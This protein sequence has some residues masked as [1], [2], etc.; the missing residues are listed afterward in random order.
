MPSSKSSS[1][2]PGKKQNG[3][4]VQLQK[5]TKQ[6]LS[7][8]LVGNSDDDSDGAERSTAPKLSIATKKP[9]LVSTK[10]VSTKAPISTA[11][12][13]KKE[14]APG[15]ESGEDAPS[16]SGSES[17]G[18]S[19]D[20]DGGTS[21][22]IPSSQEDNPL[23]VRPQQ[24][25][26]QLS[27]PTVSRETPK[28]GKVSVKHMN[29]IKTRKYGKDE[30]DSEEDSKSVS[31][32]SGSGSESESG[33][34]DQ[35]SLQSP[36][37]KSPTRRPAREQTTQ[38]YKPPPGFEPAS[39]SVHPSS[40]LSEIFAPSNLTGKQ[41]WHITAPASVP[42]ASIK[43]IRGKSIENGTSVLTHNGANYGLLPDA[44][45]EQAGDYALLLPTAQS[46]D[47]SSSKRS[48]NQTLHLQKFVSL[49]SHA[50]PPTVPRP[51]ATAAPVSYK[52][53]SRPQPQGL[54]MRYHPFGASDESESES[55]LTESVPAAPQFQ[56]PNSVNESS[57]QRKRKR[58]ESSTVE[59]GIDATPARPKKRGRKAPQESAQL[60]PATDLPVTISA[61]PADI[62]KE[63]ATIMPEEV[64]EGNPGT[65]E[66][67]SKKKR[68]ADRQKQREME[69]ESATI[70]QKAS[71]HVETKEE[72][73]KR[74]QE[75]KKRRQA[76]HDT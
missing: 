32:S 62:T 11:I 16:G 41:I 10:T 70:T 71:G 22:R 24:K 12:V 40:K 76:A 3:K 56:V 6:A 1:A 31:D 26:A 69:E 57:P 23:P 7:T 42:L 4:T 19:Q 72:R 35:T 58:S 39:I 75:K 65:K 67:S 68:K 18:K 47:Y 50:A 29:H 66:S 30:G 8:E 21:G 60:E 34:S 27:R 9:N 28:S 54:K 45:G 51:D 37:K 73:A 74:K 17:E 13:S 48:I 2:L 14:R 44:D 20:T 53:K 64:V 49:P 59:Q 63:A 25:A 38:P 61:L 36:R 15:P 43:E 55:M 52:E 33:S 46:N 5:P